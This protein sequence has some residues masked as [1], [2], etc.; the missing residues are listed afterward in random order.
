MSIQMFPGVAGHGQPAVDAA[1][2]SSIIAYAE[3]ILKIAVNIGSTTGSRKTTML[4]FGV[5]G[6]SQDNCD[7]IAGQVAQAVV[8][9]SKGYIVA[10]LKKLGK[11]RIDEGNI[12]S[13]PQGTSQ[14]GVITWTNS[15][16]EGSAVQPVLNV[17]ETVNGQ[18]YIPFVDVDTMA[19]SALTAL[20]TLI[21][22]G[23][24]ARAR[25]ANDDRDSFIIGK[26]HDRLGVSIK[27]FG[28]TTYGVLSSNDEAAG[29]ADSVLRDR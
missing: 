15:N 2:G 17:S 3:Y 20:T 24:L 7:L 1:D 28:T 5:T 26:S 12:T 14:Y 19:G 23:T 9:A 16:V 6:T 29:I 11:F 27:D 13:V 25:F 22:N 18:I 8:D 10:F 4:D 21:R